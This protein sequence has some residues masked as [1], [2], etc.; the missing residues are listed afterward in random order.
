MLSALAP[1]GT[2]WLF[3]ADVCPIHADWF[4]IITGNTGKSLGRNWKKC[5]FRKGKK[6]TT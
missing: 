2:F 4:E 3:A 5:G 1:A 6:I